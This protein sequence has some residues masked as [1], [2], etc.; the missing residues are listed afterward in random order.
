MR[1][2]TMP[3]V[4]ADLVMDAF[5]D[6]SRKEEVVQLIVDATLDGELDKLV[7]FE[8]LLMIGSPRA[9]DLGIDPLVDIKNL[10][11]LAQIWNNWAVEFR[12]DPR[13]KD[14][15]RKL[16][17]VDFWQKHGWPDRCGPTSLN[18]FECI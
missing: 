6:P 13:F 10:Q 12:Q 9:F 3:A 18:D 2:G 15:V 16:G 14:W 1:S 11:L 5:E 8:S 4:Y 17:Y 7:G